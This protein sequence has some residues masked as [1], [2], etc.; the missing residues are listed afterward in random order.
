MSKLLRAFYRIFIKNRFIR[1]T[2][3]LAL[4]LFGV[5]YATERGLAWK[6]TPLSKTVVSI[7]AE[8]VSA[9][10]IRR[11]ED[12]EITFTIGDS[13]WLV[14]KNNITLRLPVD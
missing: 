3:M 4:V 9:F 10:T 1:W 8:S 2:W 5:R 13:A 12:D 6:K 7:T 11:G 14:V